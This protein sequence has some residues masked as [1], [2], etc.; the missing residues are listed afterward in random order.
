MLYSGKQ[1]NR[2]N[3]V[4]FLTRTLVTAVF[5]AALQLYLPWWGM[6][7]GCFLAALIAL[8]IKGSVFMSAFTAVF[9][10]W[11]GYATFIDIQTSSIL[12][13]KVV[14]LLPLPEIPAL[15]IILTGLTGGL[16]AGFAAIAGDSFGKV[17]FPEKSALYY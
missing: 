14:Q 11:A 8:R 6:L 17:F 4:G 15:L 5:A 9:L 2:K 13:S 7:L 1:R 12:S 3:R 16:A 10:V